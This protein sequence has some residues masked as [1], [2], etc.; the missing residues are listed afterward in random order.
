MQ[1]YGLLGFVWYDATDPHHGALDWKITSPPAFAAFSKG[2]KTDLKP[3]VL[4]A[5]S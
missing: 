5:P 1:E 3:A 2:V 4:Q